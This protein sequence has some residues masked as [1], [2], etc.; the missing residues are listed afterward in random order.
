MGCLCL[1]CQEESA[2]EDNSQALG[3]NSQLTTL[4]LDLSAQG[5]DVGF[6]ADSTHCFNLRLPVEVVVNGQQIL[7]TDDSGYDAVTALFNQSDT[8][9]DHIEYGFPV[10]VV[11]ANGSQVTVSN[12]SQYDA[13][14][15]ACNGQ[16]AYSNDCIA[17]NY[18]ITILGYDSS[19]QLEQTHTI[20]NDAE[21]FTLLAA[22]GSN[23]Y[24]AI[25]YPLSVL[26]NGTE[27]VVSSNAQFEAAINNAIA[28]CNTG[29]NTACTNPGVLTDSLVVYMPFSNNVND[30]KGG[31][32]IAPAD[33]TFVADRN[34]N[35]HC[36]I[37]FNGSQQLQ[38]TA[39][40]ANRIADG[41]ALSIS[42]WFKMQNT[43]VGDYEVFFKKG[44]QGT[45]GF[46]AA[47][48][49]M[50]TPLFAIENSELWD[51]PW[52]QGGDAF[53]YD[54]ANWHHLVI[55]LSPNYEAKLYRD[56]VLQN[57]AA[58]VNGSI[59]ATALDYFIGTGFTGYLDD[60]RVYR[61]KELTAAEVQILFELE[62]DCNICL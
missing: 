8:D 41:D 12:Q 16:Q 36:A 14:A 56:G 37:A 42:L 25:G 1:S 49:D 40:A 33:T 22:I 30:L 60:L 53:W 26:I 46:T 17:I 2:V 27:L 43:E 19:F 59:G 52:N 58:F 51:D 28:S 7:I 18:P 5:A 44:A 50:N 38:L 13:L 20:N 10:T 15:G 62:G 45:A 32:V 47:A 21:L 11:F 31:T 48:Y 6:V 55:T 24:Y 57:S 54:T 39:S 29:N 3:A 9:Q 35:S 34:G 61:N 4:L 23:E